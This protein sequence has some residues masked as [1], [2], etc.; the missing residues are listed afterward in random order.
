MLYRYQFKLSSNQTVYISF[1]YLSAFITGQLLQ[2]GQHHYCKFQIFWQT[3]LIRLKNIL[4]RKFTLYFIKLN[5][6]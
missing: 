1:V 2:M 5:V 3:F 6:S 4:I